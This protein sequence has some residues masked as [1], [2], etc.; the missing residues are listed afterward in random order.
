MVDR[1]WP[2]DPEFDKFSMLVDVYGNIVFSLKII[3]TK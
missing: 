2:A 1:I 3:S